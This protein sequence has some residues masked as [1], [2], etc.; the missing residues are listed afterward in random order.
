MGGGAW[1]A[2]CPE[3]QNEAMAKQMPPRKNAR[4]SNRK[5]SEKVSGKS[6]VGIDAFDLA[7]S[8]SFLSRQNTRRFSEVMFSSSFLK[9]TS[10]FFNIILLRQ[11]RRQKKNVSKAS[12]IPPG[13]AMIQEFRASLRKVRIPAAKTPYT[14]M[15][16]LNVLSRWS[17]LSFQS[18]IMYL[19]V[20]IQSTSPSL[21]G[22]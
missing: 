4:N 10:E 7:S 8:H 12:Q 9:I 14:M 1:A 6:Q 20:S 16:K 17:A 2:C 15:K 19:R 18:S 13:T 11:S 21:F 3:T 22:F 5:D